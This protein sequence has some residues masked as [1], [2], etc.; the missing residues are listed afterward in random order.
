MA[1]AVLNTS[2]KQGD[3][4]GGVWDT[5]FVALTVRWFVT[6]AG[7]NPPGSDGAPQEWGGAPRGELAQLRGVHTVLNATFFV[8]P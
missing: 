4:G 1:E 8:F 7:I 2:P 6:A 5:Q 3:R